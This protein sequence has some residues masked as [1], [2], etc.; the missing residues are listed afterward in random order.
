MRKLLALFLLMIAIKTFSQE[1][2][3][4]NQKSEK[5]DKIYESP[6]IKG[7]YGFR[8]KFYQ[9]FDR[10]KVNGKGTLKSEATFIV[11]SEGKITKIE[12]TGTN[13]SMNN[14]MERTINEINKFELIPKKLNGK[15]T[16]FKY[17]FPLEL[18]FMSN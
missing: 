3:P 16:D 15:P 18:S 6:F 4:V 2:I 17:T 5:V 14:E 8:Q 9:I 12:V 7:G 11:T 1:N 13:I 10:D